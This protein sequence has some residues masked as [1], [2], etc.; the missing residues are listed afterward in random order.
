[1]KLLFLGFFSLVFCSKSFANDNFFIHRLGDK[2]VVIP[3][4]VALDLKHVNK[5][6]GYDCEHLAW[7]AKHFLETAKRDNCKDNNFTSAT[8]VETYK[9]A[10]VT[11]TGLMEYRFGDAYGKF[12]VQAK[13]ANNTAEDFVDEL[14]IPASN[15]NLINPT[16]DITSLRLN[17]AP[18]EKS[19][20]TEF[21]NYY[22]MGGNLRNDGEFVYTT[23]RAQTCALLHKQ[24]SISASLFVSTRLEKPQDINES[25]HIYNYY[26]AV[27]NT[28]DREFDNKEWKNK[29]HS[30]VSASLLL[31]DKMERFNLKNIYSVEQ[32]FDRFFT[33]YIENDEFS[34]YLNRFKTFE[35]FVKKVHPATTLDV[36]ETVLA[37][38]QE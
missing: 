12:L 26:L 23:N 16:L 13:P 20:F 17:L 25:Y 11:M 37:T 2:A 24:S 9:G 19:I 29:L 10:H 28:W 7:I 5:V 1:M 38:T 22:D 33:Y 14:G 35:D 15:I 21:I 36:S 30:V 3:R 31:N 8:C 6:Q 18:T 4:T 27:M 34:L 32:I